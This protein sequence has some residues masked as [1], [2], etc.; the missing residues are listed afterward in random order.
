MRW[1]TTESFG[2]GVQLMYNPTFRQPES[3]SLAMEPD[4]VLEAGGRRL[5][6][7]AKFKFDDATPTGSADEDAKLKAKRAD[8]EKMHAYR[9]AVRGAVGAYILFPG[10]EPQFFPAHGRWGVGAVPLTPGKPSPALKLL[11]EKFL[12]GDDGEP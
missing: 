7:D 8:F 9:D 6:L 11:L 2:P 12:A 1:G 5:L 4:I 10:T 3:Y